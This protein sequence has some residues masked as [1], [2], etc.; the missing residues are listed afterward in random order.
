VQL[1]GIGLEL[2][3]G[4]GRLQPCLLVEIAAIVEHRIKGEIGTDI[5]LPPGDMVF[6]TGSKNTVSF[7]GEDVG[8]ELEGRI[9]VAHRLD[10]AAEVHLGE[11]AGIHDQQIVLALLGTHRVALLL[12]RAGEG[13]DVELDLV[14]ALL[15]VELDGLAEAVE[16][17]RLVDDDGDGRDL[18]CAEP[19]VGPPAKVAAAP[20]PARVRRLSRSDARSSWHPSPLLGKPML[21]FTPMPRPWQ[22]NQLMRHRE[23]TSMRRRGRRAESRLPRKAL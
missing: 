11:P 12:E 17:R 3:E 8:V 21:P 7:E 9:D 2:G 1:P 14:A 22:G 16:P 19:M 10:E 13:I 20:I 5:S 6:F 4:L 18:V 23:Q 15:L